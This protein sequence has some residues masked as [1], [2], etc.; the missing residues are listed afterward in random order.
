MIALAG[1]KLLRVMTYK[2]AAI[3]NA[4]YPATK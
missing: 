2:K 1:T 3:T 4:S